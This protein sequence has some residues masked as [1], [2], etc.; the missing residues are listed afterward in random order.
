MIVSQNKYKI[1]KRSS[2]LVKM[3]T[4]FF[5][6]SFMSQTTMTVRLSGELSEF[7]ADNVGDNGVY[8]NI[9]EYV[10]NLIR[11]DK[12]RVE[13][14]KFDRLKME[15]AVAFSTPDTAYSQLSAEDVFTRNYTK[16]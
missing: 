5:K 11:N 10:R 8:E 2:I 13:Q 16:E 9:S 12:K 1:L 7:V 4:G 3:I 15:L 6:E 14:E